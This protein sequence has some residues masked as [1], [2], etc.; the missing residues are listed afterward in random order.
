[1]TDSA[2][3][4]SSARLN[5]LVKC[6]RGNL[7]SIDLNDNPLGVETV[8]SFLEYIHKQVREEH[9]PVLV[10]FMCLG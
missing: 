4:E 9:G 1:M 3:Q 8:R 2:T 7:R 6:G 10:N 5:H